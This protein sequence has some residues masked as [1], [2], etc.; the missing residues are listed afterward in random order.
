MKQPSETRISYS[1]PPC[2][3]LIAV[4]IPR[5]YSVRPGEPGAALAEQTLHSFPSCTH[6]CSSTRSYTDFFGRKF[7]AHYYYG[8]KLGFP[9]KMQSVTFHEV[10]LLILYLTLGSFVL[11]SGICAH[12]SLNAVVLRSCSVSHGVRDLVAECNL[13]TLL[14]QIIEP[15]QT[16]SAA[17]QC[18]TCAT[19]TALLGAQQ[20]RRMVPVWQNLN[21]KGACP[22]ICN[23]CDY[24]P[25]TVKAAGKG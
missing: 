8:H 25:A 23:Y 24:V 2:Q 12:V 11:C 9:L 20:I 16:R 14:Q 7:W 4:S 17:A 22:D 13:V 3:R 5:V 10:E 6:R 1:G 19:S 18:T 15:N 21:A